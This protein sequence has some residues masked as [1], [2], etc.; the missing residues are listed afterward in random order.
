MGVSLYL[1][2]DHSSAAVD[3]RGFVSKMWA[4]V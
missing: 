3:W 1:V 4:P 2:L